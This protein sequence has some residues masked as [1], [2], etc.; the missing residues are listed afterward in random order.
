[1]VGLIEEGI[2][3]TVHALIVFDVEDGGVGGALKAL[4]GGGVEEGSG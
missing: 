1:M 2:G 4:V 3:S